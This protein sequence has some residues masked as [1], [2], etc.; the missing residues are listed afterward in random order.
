MSIGGI[1]WQMRPVLTTWAERCESVGGGPKLMKIRAL[2]TETIGTRATSGLRQ[3]PIWAYGEPVVRL[4]G[5]SCC[6][7]IAGQA[8][9]RTGQFRRDVISSAAAS[10]SRQSGLR[11]RLSSRALNSWRRAPRSMSL[12]VFSASK[13]YPVPSRHASTS[14]AR[15]LTKR[16]QPSVRGSPMR[17][18]SSSNELVGGS[19]R[20]ATVSKVPSKRGA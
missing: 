4:L 3:S 13:S 12:T 18:R 11:W 10:R 1:R 2:H 8:H 7:D 20:A 6:A 16:V 17:S 14:S 15:L 5:D 9:A 19:T